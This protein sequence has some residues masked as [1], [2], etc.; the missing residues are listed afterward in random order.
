M[1]YF[2]SNSSNMPWVRKCGGGNVYSK[3]EADGATWTVEDLEENIFDNVIDLMVKYFLPEAPMAMRID[4]HKDAKNVEGVR[5]FLMFAL[6]HRTSLVCYRHYQDRRTI[7]AV[8]VCPVKCV[9]DKEYDLSQL[10]GDG[11]RLQT[12]TLNYI[13]TYVDIFD[14]LDVKQYLSCAG[15]L[16]LPEFRGARL[17][18]KLLA[19]RE[20]M[21]KLLGISGT[22]TL[23]TGPASQSLATRC[24][25]VTLFEKSFEDLAKAGF[26]YPGDQSKT[27]KMMIKKYDF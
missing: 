14:A 27:V 23:F 19:A 22:A 6:S 1:V 8:N 13:D 17:G 20:P 24:G 10:E 16:V 11:I 3:W 9:D 4:F 25:F 18:A 5:K 2:I 15:L 21:C 12:D 7:V 26:Y